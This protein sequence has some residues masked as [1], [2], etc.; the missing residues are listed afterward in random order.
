SNYAP[1]ISKKEGHIDFTKTPQEIERII[2][3]FTPWPGTYFYYGDKMVK[4]HKAQVFTA[5]EYAK[6]A[7]GSLIES[8]A[9]GTVIAASKDGLD[10]AAGGGV[11]RA[12]E[13][14]MP[15]KKRVEFREF[16]KGNSIEIG[17]VLG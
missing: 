4:L 15:G 17:T 16:L 5:E 11:L 8:A 6:E 2:R 3:A 7:K 9:A 1:M 12:V 14:Q 10:I 13:I